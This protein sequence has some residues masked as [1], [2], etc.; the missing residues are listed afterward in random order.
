MIQKIVLLALTTL[1]ITS[2]NNSVSETVILSF[3]KDLIPEGVAIDS[4]SG[5]VFLSSLKKN[6]IVAANINGS[7]AA[8]FIENG[9]Y[10]YLSGFGMTIKGDTLY[11]LGN[12]LK[13]KD[14]TSVLLLLNIKT[15]Q[16][17]KTQFLNLS[18]M[19]MTI[20]LFK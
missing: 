3:E 14:N 1:T 2:C 10:D 12:G 19:M 13:K 15:N 17:F 7:N 5:R 4:K 18:N 9:Q 6:K 16:L 11:A 8:N 20:M